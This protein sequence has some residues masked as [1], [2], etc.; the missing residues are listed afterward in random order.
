MESWRK[1]QIY[2][3]LFW[4][5]WK[6][7]YLLSLR[8]K[9]PIYHKGST[10]IQRLPEEGDV[11]LVK[12][13]NLPRSSWKLGR[14]LHLISGKDGKVQSAKILLPGHTTVS[15]AINCLYPLELPACKDEQKT[16]QV[17]F[18]SLNNNAAVLFLSPGNVVEI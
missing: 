12:D 8:E 11:V 9:L 4:R 16:R 6:D 18:E 10:E 17:I 1:G 2:L 15:R 3:N 14:I 13:D 7:E 5:V